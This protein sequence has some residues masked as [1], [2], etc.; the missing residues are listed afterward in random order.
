MLATA[1]SVM[2]EGKESSNRAGE[3]SEVLFQA[4]AMA[5]LLVNTQDPSHSAKQPRT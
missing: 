5:D 2:L 3:T 4:F 1:A